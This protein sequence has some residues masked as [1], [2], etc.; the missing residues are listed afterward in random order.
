MPT[1]RLRVVRTLA[2]AFETFRVLR[3]MHRP[4]W[5]FRA[6]G[7]VPAARIGRRAPNAV[8]EADVELSRRLI[9][10]YRRAGERAAPGD[11]GETMWSWIFSA[12][13]HDLATALEAEDAQSLATLMAP[14]FRQDFALDVASAQL[15]SETDSR[16]GSR[17][18]CLRSFDWLVSLAEAVGAAPMENPEQGGIGL[19]FEAEPADLLAALDRELGFRLDFPDVG[20]PRGL[21][22]EGRLITP[23]TPDQVY[24]AV[25]LDDAIELHMDQAADDVSTP[26]VVEIGGGY[27]GM[28]H[29]FLQ[30]RN[31]VARYTIV[32][33][34]IMNALQG[35]FLTHTLG[36]ER[37]SFYGEDPKQVHLIPN[38]ALA[39]VETPFE[40]LVNKDSLPEMPPDAVMS[41]LE[42][43]GGNCRGLFYSYNQE[44]GA[45]FLGEAQGVVAR[46]VAQSGQFERLRRDLAWVRP[47]YVEEIFVPTR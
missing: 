47:G 45:P 43:A 7:R 41:Y 5:W 11:S 29:W 4:L 13:Q 8:T 44:A 32:D 6:R 22:I 24:A 39:E 9:D 23:D 34:P 36:P 1:S 31:A 35:Y 42:W 27:G 15:L 26:R 20:A 18:W 3:T 10:A 28:C 38:S 37:V 30:R 21:E 16:I 12:R 33:L 19:A 17:I 25:R 14:M 40:V 2:R 46:S